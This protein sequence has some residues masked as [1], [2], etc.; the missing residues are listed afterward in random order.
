LVHFSQFWYPARR[1]IWQSRVTQTQP[2]FSDFP[3]KKANEV[4]CQPKDG[5]FTPHIF[6]E[7]R[8]KKDFIS[9][10]KRFVFVAGRRTKNKK[11]V[12]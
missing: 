12:V 8:K 7:S 2:E 3:P 9:T 6:I 5:K 4:S 1:K 11:R 10:L